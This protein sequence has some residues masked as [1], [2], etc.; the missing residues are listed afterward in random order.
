MIRNENLNLKQTL[1]ASPILRF[2]I[3]MQWPSLFD[4]ETMRLFIAAQIKFSKKVSAFSVSFFN[5]NFSPN[6]VVFS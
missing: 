3:R 4:D 6:F 2:Q 1:L 5:L